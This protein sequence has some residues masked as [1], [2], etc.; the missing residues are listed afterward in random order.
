[1]LREWRLVLIRHG[2]TPSN[3]RRAYLGKTEEDLSESGKDELLKQVQKGIYPKAALVFASPMRRCMQTAE[4]IY[5]DASIVTVPEWTEMDF[6]DFEGKNYRELSERAD[7]QAWI[8]G[9]GT[10]A[11][12]N[13]EDRAH[14]TKRCIAGLEKLYACLAELA[15][16][17]AVPTIAAV[18]HGGTIMALLSECCGG[19]YFDYQVENG[20]GYVCRIFLENKRL[21][22][23]NKL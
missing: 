13:G 5:P 19:D 4:L 6:G 16:D 21:E 22:I 7:Y 2:Q 11:F 3:R 17:I 9:G 1:M 14:F 15:E 18:V 8:A 20:K 23:E 10:S 12:P